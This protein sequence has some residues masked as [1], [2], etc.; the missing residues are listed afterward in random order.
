MLYNPWVNFP[1]SAHECY[2]P[3]AKAESNLTSAIFRPSWTD[4][5]CIPE[6]IFCP[7]CTD[8]TEWLISRDVCKSRIHDHRDY[9]DFRLVP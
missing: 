2:Y 5:K 6:A 8:Y 7:Q 3:S 1:D 4:T 9:R